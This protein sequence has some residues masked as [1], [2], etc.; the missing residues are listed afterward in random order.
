MCFHKVPGIHRSPPPGHM[1]DS[2]QYFSFRFFYGNLIF[3]TFKRHRQDDIYLLRFFLSSLSNNHCII[4]PNICQEKS[5]N[6]LFF[7][8]GALFAPPLAHSYFFPLAPVLIAPASRNAGVT[9]GYEASQRQPLPSPKSDLSR[10]LLKH[11][12]RILP[13]IPYS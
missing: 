5:Y 11:A 12:D 1:N 2:E 10:N 9:I 8:E 4:S 7:F 6:F 3:L 13:S